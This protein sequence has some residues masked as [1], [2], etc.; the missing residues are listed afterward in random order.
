MSTPLI[1]LPC[2]WSGRILT[3][4]GLL[5]LVCSPWVNPRHGRGPRSSVA[6]IANR[7]TSQPSIS[8]PS[9]TFTK[10]LEMWFCGDIYK[11]ISSYRILSSKDV[12]HVQGGNQ[13]WSNMKYLV[14]QVI[15]ATGILNRHDLFIKN[16]S[17]RKVM[18]LYLG[19]RN[20]FDF[21][22]L[23]SDKRRRYEKIYW[24]TYFNALLKRK[25][26]L[27]VEQRWNVTRWWDW[28]GTSII[29]NVNPCIYFHFSK[30]IY[31]DYVSG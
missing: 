6:A 25:G 15:R 24:K 17:P 16:W 8:I 2:S 29:Q 19:V 26:K 23:Y 18:D 22:C 5:A 31:T 4:R 9:M 7:G 14:K 10:M 12:K 11:H 1:P 21:P 20:F 28:F 13:K 3:L 27:F 30:I